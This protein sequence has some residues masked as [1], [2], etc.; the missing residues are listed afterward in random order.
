MHKVYNIIMQD[1][2]DLKHINLQHLR[3]PF[4][5]FN[6]GKTSAFQIVQ[7]CFDDVALLNVLTG[8]IIHRQIEVVNGQAFWPY[9]SC[10]GAKLWA[11]QHLNTS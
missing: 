9:C 3:L 4:S 8:D 11:K 5:S 10:F 7:N 6:N 2:L 1:L